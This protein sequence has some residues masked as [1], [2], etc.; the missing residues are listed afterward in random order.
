MN[1]YL[2]VEFHCHSRY[3]PDSLNS[4]GKLIAT[5]KARGIDRLVITDHNTIRGALLAKELEP[6][7]IIVGEEIKTQHGELLA[8]FVTEEIPP[9][10]DPLDVIERLRQQGA[11]ISVSHPFDRARGGWELQHL[12]DIV[13]KVDAIEVFNARCLH[14]LLN[15]QAAAFA[16][17]HRLAGTVGSDAHT[18]VEV[19]QATLLLPAFETGEELRQAIHLGRPEVRLSPF[20]VHL[21]S[22]YARFYKM[23]TRDDRL[24]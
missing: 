7:R 20:W 17:E 5:A 19:G 1:N 4:V 13:A 11:F 24:V 15:E 2:K 3:S 23:I 12:R 10:L 6:E 16:K 8:A 21:G 22:S 9:L 14:P 18:L